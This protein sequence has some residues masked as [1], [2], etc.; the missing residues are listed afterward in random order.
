MSHRPLVLY[1][2]FSSSLFCTFFFMRICVEMLF[3]ISHSLCAMQNTWTLLLLF[4][5]LSFL[6][7]LF[8]IQWMYELF[9]SG[10]SVLLCLSFTLSRWIKKKCIFFKFVHVEILWKACFVVFCQWSVLEMSFFFSSSFNFS[11]HS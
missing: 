2:F 4:L 7:F 6:S 10:F 11:F 9:V 8:V 1:Y 5:Y 3:I